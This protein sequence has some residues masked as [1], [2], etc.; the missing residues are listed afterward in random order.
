MTASDAPLPASLLRQ[1]GGRI[2]AVRL[3]REQTGSTL[4]DAQRA[5]QRI[6][7]KR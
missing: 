3:H 4:L 7:R 5:V 1:D 2:A 6:E